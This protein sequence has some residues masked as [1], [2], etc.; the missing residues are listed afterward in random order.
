MGPGGCDVVWS[1]GIMMCEA[2]GLCG[3]GP[4]DCVW[5]LEVMMWDEAWRL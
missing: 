2:W 1:L 3:V 5:S 4:G